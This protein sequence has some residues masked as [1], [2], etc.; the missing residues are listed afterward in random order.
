M[1]TIFY[2]GQCPLCTKEIAWLQKRMTPG[3]VLFQDIT[4]AVFSPQALGKTMP[5]MMQA[6]HVR[7]QDGQW[8]TAMAATRLIYQEA[9]LGWLV[10]PTAWPGLAPIFD[11]LYQRFARLRPR[12]QKNHGHCQVPPAY[13]SDD[14]VVAF[15][16]RTPN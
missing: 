8:Y 7:D 16:R 6:L 15:R 4:V 1:I 3:R 14:R 2:D 10:A 5:A 11:W 13:C 12:L 9:G